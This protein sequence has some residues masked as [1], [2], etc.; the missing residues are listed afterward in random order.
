MR[1]LYEFVRKRCN[2]PLDSIM[3]HQKRV[4][5]NTKISSTI[6]TNQ[7]YFQKIIS[8]PKLQKLDPILKIKIRFN[9][10]SLQSQ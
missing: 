1:D 10:I 9:G 7:K 6:N 5:T 8:F 3:N 4:P 2:F